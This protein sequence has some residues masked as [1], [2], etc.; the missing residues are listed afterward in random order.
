MEQGSQQQP[1]GAYAAA[2]PLARRLG[3][4]KEKQTIKLGDCQIRKM[5]RK[6][7]G[8]GVAGRETGKSF[9]LLE[10]PIT[11]S[12]L[13]RSGGQRP[14]HLPTPTTPEHQN[15]VFF[16]KIRKEGEPNSPNEKILGEQPQ[17]RLCCSKTQSLPFFRMGG[18]VPFK[19]TWV[20][21]RRTL[22]ERTR[23]L[24]HRRRG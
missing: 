23:H 9:S 20:R 13:G 10:E 17:T 12:C 4:P 18:L 22:R 21:R 15:S 6:N 19:L 16:L 8:S 11:R 14:A 24:R 2:S 5:L 1:L 3:S 7:P